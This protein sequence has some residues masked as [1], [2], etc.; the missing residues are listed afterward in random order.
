MFLCNILTLSEKH[1]EAYW[2]GHGSTV[3]KNYGS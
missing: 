1:I 2:R 3:S